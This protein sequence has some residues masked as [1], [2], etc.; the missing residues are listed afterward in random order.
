MEEG[1]PK[2][3]FEA[4]ERLGEILLISDAKDIPRLDRLHHW[5]YGLLLALLGGIGRSLETLADLASVIASTMAEV[6]E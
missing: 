3:A 4:L 2:E 5:Q 6:V 1:K